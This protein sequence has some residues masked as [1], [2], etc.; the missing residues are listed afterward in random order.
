MNDALV[1]QARASKHADDL[2]KTAKTQPVGYTYLSN[3]SNA[4]L[5]TVHASTCKDIAKDAWR[6]AAYADGI[7]ATL[8]E[9]GQSIADCY[10]G[11]AAPL[12]GGAEGD[13]PNDLAHA[14]S[15]AK[16]QAC[17]KKAGLEVSR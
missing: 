15:W 3:T 1:N 16:F 6:C 14:L 7:H 8:E 10:G 13:A 5:F 2:I 4:A 12:G 9:L 17:V 11:Y